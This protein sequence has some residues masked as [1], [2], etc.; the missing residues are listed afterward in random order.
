MFFYDF[1]LP[2]AAI[3]NI[4]VIVAW[5]VISSNVTVFVRF[6]GIPGR[7]LLIFL[8]AHRDCAII[9]SADMNPANI[10][11]TF[12]TLREI[13]IFSSLITFLIESGIFVAVWSW[14]KGGVGVVWK[15]YDNWIV[16]NLFNYILSLPF[17]EV[18]WSLADWLFW[19][20]RSLTTP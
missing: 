16:L 15:F 3:M 1:V 12:H 6:L 19:L 8:T 10:M 7:L 18:V 2:M 5:I 14:A 20:S 17:D 11:M 13:I 4:V 9:V